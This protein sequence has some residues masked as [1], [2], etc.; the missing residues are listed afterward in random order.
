MPEVSGIVT[1][2]ST[3]AWTD[4]IPAGLVCQS[5]QSLP[6]WHCCTGPHMGTAGQRGRR[7]SKPESS[8]HLD[9][10]EVRL[11]YYL[12]DLSHACLPQQWL[13]CHYLHV[14]EIIL[15][16]GERSKVGG[17][18]EKMFLA[19][20]LP[21]SHAKFSY[22]SVLENKKTKPNPRPHRWKSRGCKFSDG[23]WAVQHYIKFDLWHPRVQDNSL[24]HTHSQE[25]WLCNAVWPFHILFSLSHNIARLS[26]LSQK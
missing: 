17:R 20:L 25:K 3:C 15:L 26:L 14:M 16:T 10:H 23:S 5:E 4:T 2:F 12:S 8:F 11:A 22:F 9:F 1:L 19:C 6:E 24:K 21:T 18:K 7:T 13:A